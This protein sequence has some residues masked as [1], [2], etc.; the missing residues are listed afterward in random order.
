M[1]PE[2]I[3]EEKIY[4]LSTLICD[5]EA[6]SREAGTDTQ[7]V[8][9]QIENVAQSLYVY[10]NALKYEKLFKTQVAEIDH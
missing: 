10:G 9:D 3:I 5:L 4:R 7:S 1:S 2:K 6:L 8:Y